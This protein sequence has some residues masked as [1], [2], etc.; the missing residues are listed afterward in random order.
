MLAVYHVYWLVTAGTLCAVCGLFCMCLVHCVLYKAWQ[1]LYS[2]YSV[3]YY[4]KS[5]YSA[6]DHNQVSLHAVSTYRL[7]LSQLLHLFSVCAC[8]QGWGVV[9]SECPVRQRDPEMELYNS[10][11]TFTVIG[12]PHGMDVTENANIARWDDCECCHSGLV[13]SC[14]RFPNHGQSYLGCSHMTHGLA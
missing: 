9:R 13:R 3:L 6:S 12:P 14:N 5:L 8:V 10:W 2:V 11:L 7:V 4:T 1:V